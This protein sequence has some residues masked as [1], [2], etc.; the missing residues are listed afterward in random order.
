LKR[1]ALRE[2]Q[3]Q[4]LS[5]ARANGLR[6]CEARMVSDHATADVVR[7][8]EEAPVLGGDKLDLPIALA[9]THGRDRHGLPVGSDHVAANG[10]VVTQRDESRR[11]RAR[12]LDHHSSRRE[13]A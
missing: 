8:D 4:R 11:S 6:V 12:E 10:G 1:A 2:P 3:H 9:H 7:R 13:G 5:T